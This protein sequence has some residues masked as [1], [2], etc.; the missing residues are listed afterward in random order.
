MVLFLS[1]Y[2]FVVVGKVIFI[3]RFIDGVDIY[4]G[5]FGEI[6]EYEGFLRVKMDLEE[7]RM[8]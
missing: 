3:L 4:F 7:C 2:I 6:S 1:F 5:M 8:C